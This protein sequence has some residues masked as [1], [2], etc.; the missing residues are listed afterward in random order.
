MKKIMFILLG[1]SNAVTAQ[2]LEA[3]APPSVG[4]TLET[5]FGLEVH[6]PFR[7]M[8]DVDSPAVA[9]WIADKNQQAKRLFKSVSEYQSI[10]TE[11]NRFADGSPVRGYIPVVNNGYAYALRTDSRSD[12][13][14]VVRYNSPSDSGTVLFTSQDITTRLGPNY[15]ISSFNP[16][17]NNQY[18]ALELYNESDEVEIHVFDI[19][20]SQMANDVVDASIS[21]YPYWLPNSKGFFYTQLSSPNDSVDLFDDVRVKLH[22]VETSQTHDQVVLSGSSSQ[23]LPY[24][25]GDFPTIQ[26][27]P[28]SLTA[29]CSLSRGISQY[30]E[31]FVIPLEDL[32]SQRDHWKR[33][34][35]LEDKVVK[36]V[37]D[38]TSAYL[39]RSK[40][41][42]TTVVTK[43]NLHDTHTTEEIATVTGGFINDVEV[44]GQAIYLETI[45]DGISSILRIDQHGR[46]E[47]PLPFAGDV[48]LKASGFPSKANGKGLFFGLASWNKGYGIYYY[49]SAADTVVRTKIRPV[50]TYDLPEGLVVE[51][52]KV[53]SHDSVEVPLSIVYQEGLK[54]NGDSPVILEAYGAYGMSL[55]PY[56]EVEMLA[57]Y[58]RG[59]IV[60][61]AHVRG[62]G[63]K[64]AHWH[65]QGRKSKK[66]N[67]WK[68]LIA[69]GQYLLDQEYT[70]PTKLGLT[71]A[72][73]GGIAAGMAM[74]KRPDM[75]GAVVLEYPF[76]NPVRLA[77][78]VDGEIHYDEFGD[79]ADS[80]EFQYLY[81]MDP[82]MH[83]KQGTDYPAVLLTAGINDTRV[84]VWE[85]AKFAAKLESI[86]DNDKVT[87]LRVYDN[88][89]G[90]NSTAEMNQQISDRLTF[91]IQ[92]LDRNRSQNYGQ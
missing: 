17:P 87:L 39:L 76:L 42:S 65:T 73:A 44:R 18:L 12:V 74:V 56:L 81:Q 62:G 86:R 45:T 89:H 20:A 70:N 58:R 48:D 21:Y 50:G 53:V 40:D 33:I 55:E 47:L 52:V 32:L 63:E 92:Q 91:F 90:A 57:W 82:Y 19:A 60:A 22:T 2:I 13:Q 69:C 34:N 83:L 38:S 8:E 80:S 67:S 3:V 43:I 66:A 16:S 79:P 51:E 26:V 88:G 75:F 27:L 77:A 1:L 72:S 7:G 41:E 68:D 35:T 10:S 54:R 31:Y 6:D 59:G 49:D 23:S 29:R 24:G 14:Q 15:S 71:A 9:S 61:K 5:I 36:A 78:S 4:D 46:S 30:A 28:D 11:I 37:F 85:P 64:G 84:E 25:S